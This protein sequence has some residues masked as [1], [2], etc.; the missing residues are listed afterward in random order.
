[1]KKDD[2][3]SRKFVN[4]QYGIQEFYRYERFFK[5]KQKA[6]KLFETIPFLNGGLFENLDKNIGKPDE[7]RIDCFS[8]RP[9]HEKRLQVPDFLFFGAEDQIDLSD[10]YGSKKHK[11]A[12]VR[13]IIHILNSYKFTIAENTPIEEEIALDPELLGKV[14]ENLLASYNPETKT[15]ARKQTG[16]FYTPRE[17][18]NYMVDESLIAY[19]E[20][21]LIES[22]QKKSGL[23]PKTPPSQKIMFGRQK[24]TQTKITP[25]APK[26]P[27]G[28]AKEINDKLCHL[29]SYTTEDHHFS[30]NEVRIIIAA[31]DNAKI[32]D[33]AC[34]SG[35]F[36]MGILHKMVHILSRLDPQNKQWK[37]RQIENQTRQVK[38]DI[39]YAEKIKD[40]KARQKAL[41]ELEERMATINDTFDTNE[42]DF[43]RKLYLIENC[44]FGVDI[45]PIAVQ[46]AKLRFF[47]SLVVDQLVDENKENLGIIPLPNLETKFVAADTLIGVDKKGQIGLNFQNPEINKKEREL[48]KVRERHFSART[49]NT[50]EKYRQ[51]DEYLR[52][53]IAELLKKDGFASEVTQKLAHWNPYDQNS[54]ADF[55]DMEWMFGIKNGFD[56]VIGNPPYGVSIKGDYRKAIVSYLGKVPDCEIYYFFVEIAYALLNGNGIKTFIIPNTILF[57]VFAAGYRLKMLTKWQIHEVLDC[58]DFDFFEKTTIRNIITRF[59]KKKTSEYIGYKNTK[60]ATSFMQLSDRDLLYITQDNLILNNPNWSLAFKLDTRVLNLVIK[61]KAEHKKL[62]DYFPEFSQGLIAYDKYKGQSREIIENRVYHYKSKDKNN[63]KPWLWGRDVNRFIVEWN[64]EEYIDYCDGIANPRKPKYFK[65]K[66]ILVR[67]ITNPSIYAAYTDKELYNDPAIIIILEGKKISL[68]SLL[69]ILNSTLATFYHFNSSPK[70]T[71]GE[72]P[73]ILVNDIKNFP[74]VK[75]N[76]YSKRIY[77]NLSNLTEKILSAKTTNFSVNTVSY[78]AEVDARI[79]HLYDLTEEEYALVLKETNCPDP[80]RVA[81]L[82]VYRDIAREK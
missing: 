26:M 34:G 33:P 36:P 25:S 27:V 71:K 4:R 59:S 49:P 12:T 79:A 47:I 31:L 21:N 39:S 74:L 67:E 41:D 63:L 17:I 80:F 58:T 65:G 61:I 42:L 57:N 2:P 75:I 40:D 29:L 73:K 64:K 11:N 68:L 54:F 22:F 7:V 66:R 24:P 13:G 60:D 43:G 30:E 51:K 16:S 10:V 56:I 19:L 72:F 53:E 76:T 48:A 18:V 8:N 37:Q 5:N 23:I 35:A 50:K 82:N 14:F 6:L 28:V 45:Q 32:L 15:T 69:A 70:A 9:K 44:I 1:M 52:N 77:S 46:I 38:Q 20:G 62:C 81:A 78:E 55:F 3:E